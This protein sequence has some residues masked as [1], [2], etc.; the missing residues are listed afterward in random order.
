[1][2]SKVLPAPMP[3]RA[4]WARISFSFACRRR[5]LQREVEIVEEVRLHELLVDFREVDGWRGRRRRLLEVAGKRLHLVAG[6]DLLDVVEVVRVEKLGAISRHR[7]LRARPEHLFDPGRRRALPVRPDNHVVAGLAS[8]GAGADIAVV[9]GVAVAEHDRVVALRVH[10]RDRK[11]DRL[12]PQ[13]HPHERIGRVAVRRDDRGVFVGEDVG[14]VLDLIE[15]RLELPRV[16]ID[17]IL[18]HDA[19]VHHDRQA[20]DEACLGDVLRREESWAV[21]A[22]LCQHRARFRRCGG[23]CSQGDR[24]K[25]FAFAQHL[26]PPHLDRFSSPNSAKPETAPGRSGRNAAVAHGTIACSRPPAH[27]HVRHI[28]SCWALLGWIHNHSHVVDGMRSATPRHTDL[29]HHWPREIGL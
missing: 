10:R 8:R 27:G 18:V 9:V 15:R 22:R 20:V 2:K 21:G 19:V 5:E 12:R 17:G 29:A 13:V 26:N 25:Q 7:K 4:S 6:L 1:M 24:A 28:P 3:M 11:N 14:F 23:D 16:T